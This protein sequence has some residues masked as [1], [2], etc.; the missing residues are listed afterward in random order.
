MNKIQKVLLGLVLVIGIVAIAVSISLLNSKGLQGIQGEKGDKGEQGIAGKQGS[1]GA[2]GL[3]GLQGIQGPKGNSQLG[4]IA[5]PAL[6]PW[7]S[8]GNVVQRGNTQSFRQATSTICASVAPAA[9]STLLLTAQ[10]TVATGTD[11]FVDVFKLAKNGYALSTGA[12]DSATTSGTQI[13]TTIV[14]KANDDGDQGTLLVA[15]SSSSSDINAIFAPFEQAL[16]KV[17][18]KTNDASAGGDSMN[19]TGSCGLIWREL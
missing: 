2:Q 12:T 18:M 10:M 9:T 16:V 17:A 1:A 3:R 15:S 5:S 7:F 8:V 11:V 13:G 19:L 14:W 6:G 4:A